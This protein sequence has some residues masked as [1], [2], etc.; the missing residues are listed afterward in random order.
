[1]AS[2]QSYHRNCYLPVP[3]HD[4]AEHGRLS[5]R[6]QECGVAVKF[7]RRHPVLSYCALTF[8][9]SWTAALCVAAPYL[10][11]RAPLP[12]VTGILMFPAMLMGPSLAGIILTRIVDGKDGLGDLFRRIVR[13]RVGV[14]WYA[15]LLI[16]PS[17][18]LAVLFCLRTFASPAYAP[19]NSLLG[20]AFGVPA[21]LLE[22]IGWTGYAFPRMCSEDDALAP[23][24]LLGL[25][26]SAHERLNT[27]RAEPLLPSCPY[28]CYCVKKRRETNA[29]DRYRDI[30]TEQFIHVERYS[31]R[32]RN[33]KSRSHVSEQTKW[34][35]HTGVAGSQEVL[36]ENVS[37]A[38]GKSEEKNTLDR[39]EIQYI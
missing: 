11:R 29:N 19:N 17:L 31:R 27:H 38:F 15:A 34:R 23:A 3:S 9:I 32:H 10:M 8:A 25:L 14:R 1:M 33:E 22:E 24:T 35:N 5:A 28:K 13:W 2:Q 30:P 21:G 37:P 18:V 7:F 39:D 12:K 6:V 4:F 16:P 36:K 20:V 26:W